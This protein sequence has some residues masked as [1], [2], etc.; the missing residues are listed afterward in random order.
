[1]RADLG[2]VRLVAGLVSALCICGGWFRGGPCGLERVGQ[3]QRPGRRQAFV[4][5]ASCCAS[6]GVG[7]VWVD[8]HFQ[9][10]G[11]GWFRGGP[12]GLERVGQQQRPG[13]HQAFVWFPRAVQAMGVGMVWVMCTF[14]A[15]VEAGSVGAH[16][17]SSGWDSSK[18]PAGAR[19]LWWFPRAVQAMGVGMVW[20]DVHFQCICGG[21][22]RGGPCGLERVGQQ[23]RPGR[24]QAFVVVASCCA[25]HGVGMVWGDVHFQCFCG[26]WFRGAPCGL[27]RKGQQQR[28]GRRQAFVVVASCC[29]CHGVGMV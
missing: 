19:L 25:S 24:R 2:L 7:M 4:V 5:V 14:S 17:A 9:C 29:A 20:G 11:G 28:P 1:L 27:E 6:H 26:G 18:G 16:V 22:F 23:Q 3:Q 13:R 21:W 8:V 15:S 12:C 10:I